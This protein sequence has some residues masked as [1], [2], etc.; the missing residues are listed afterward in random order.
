MRADGN[1][2]DGGLHAAVAEPAAARRQRR[3]CDKI[4]D[5]RAHARTGAADR[6]AVSGLFLLPAHLDHGRLRRR[7]RQGLGR[8]EA[9]HADGVGRGHRHSRPHDFAYPEQRHRPLACRMPDSRR[10]RPHARH[11]FQRGHHEDRLVHA[12]GAA[13]DH[14]LGDAAPEDPRTGQDHSAQSRRGEYRHF[15]TQRG[16]RPVGLCLL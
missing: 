4:G 13:D 11:G 15:E 14:V 9:G 3:Q 6:P 5:H 16:Y 8:A 12:K 2:Q 10:S 1:G 7:R